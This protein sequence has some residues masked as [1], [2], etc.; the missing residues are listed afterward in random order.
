MNALSCI[1]LACGLTLTHHPQE[2]D[3]V[4]TT[5]DLSAAL[6]EHGINIVKPPYFS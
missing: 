1:L 2:K 3:L 4:L 5:A 6:K